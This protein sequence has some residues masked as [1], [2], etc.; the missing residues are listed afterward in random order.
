MFNLD[1]KFLHNSDKGTF[2]AEKPRYTMTENIEYTVREM[3]TTIDRLLKFENRVKKEIADLSSQ[4]SSD[5]VI[6]KDTLY[7]A[8]Q[9]FQQ[10]LKNEVNLFESNVDATTKLF[11]SDI[12]NNY[13][14][15]SEDVNKQITD[16]ETNYI[17]LL[18]ELESR[19]SENYTTFAD[20]V[21]K[22]IDA[23]NTTYTQAFNDYK[24]ALTTEVN[25]YQLNVD[26]IV[27]SFTKSI[28][29]TVNTFK[30]TWEQIITDRL[31]V[32]DDRIS[33]NELYMKTNLSSTIQELIA[34]MHSSGEFS[35]I[36]QG[37]VFND[38][39][40]KIYSGNVKHFGAKGDG[41]T[42]DTLTIQECIN[43]YDKIY[44]PDGEYIVSANDEEY[45]VA[46]L[47]PS[48]KVIE[49]SP[50]ATIKMKANDKERYCIFQ[51]QNESENIIISGGNIVGERNE[52]TGTSGEWG[53]GIDIRANK[54]VIIKNIK[55]SNCWGDGIMIA[56]NINDLSIPS[57]NILLDNVI[58]D[59]N[60]R[61]GISVCG[62]NNLKINNC[63]LM[64]TNGTAPQSGIDFEPNDEN[65][66]MKNIFVN[67]LY[68][69]NNKGNGVLIVCNN[70]CEI[71]INN[72]IDE[73]GTEEGCKT[74]AQLGIYGNENEYKGVV[75]INN[76]ISKYCNAFVI[77]LNGKHKN[78]VPITINGLKVLEP[79]VLYS[80]IETC[81]V[82]YSYGSDN[83]SIGGLFINDLSVNRSLSKTDTFTEFQL[84]THYTGDL[85][86]IIINIL[87]LEKTYKS[88]S[89]T[90]KSD[91]IVND[92]NLLVFDYTDYNFS[93]SDGRPKKFIHR[94]DSNAIRTYTVKNNLP[95]SY[96]FSIENLSNYDTHI[97]FEVPLK[98]YITNTATQKLKLSNEIGAKV[99][100][101]RYDDNSYYVVSGKEY[102][103]VIEV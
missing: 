23:N 60:R 46:L 80:A 27:D 13:S 1:E 93:T 97:I 16:L 63:S 14:N 87:E 81:R 79:S 9:I 29:N 64:N 84:L 35:E 3:K 69:Y 102:I 21:S 83:Y 90:A 57:T 25:T 72:W 61:Q 7:N 22:R 17:Q 33:D 32:Q 24:S 78:S 20:S 66:P 42:D 68:T 31:R 38:L 89:C 36:I 12:E 73:C 101:K 8:W 56:N 39:T 86:N 52:H 15:L 26:T 37:E 71:T 30:Q 94:K 4:V 77:A 41:V 49:M 34:G 2:P 70:P 40:D 92:N 18:T 6:F 76:F 43:K 53:M 47:I 19:L 96:D 51:L 95:Y 59:N 55:I 45:G 82:L 98:S 62:A 85:E 44:I 99:T 28:N 100:I 91:V 74:E 65:T 10:E 75:T 67:N 11:Q 58:C 5:N 54:N 103:E 48:N 50:N 88:I